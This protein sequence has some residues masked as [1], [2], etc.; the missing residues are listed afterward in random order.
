MQPNYYN[1]FSMGLDLSI[2]RPQDKVELM[3][4]TQRV[5]AIDFLKFG[6]QLKKKEEEMKLVKDKFEVL[7]V[8][9]KEME[10]EIA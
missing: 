1:I 8:K 9:E 4:E 2:A 5:V 10:A 3:E 6:H 7:L